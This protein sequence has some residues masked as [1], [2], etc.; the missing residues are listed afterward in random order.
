MGIM[1]EDPAF[2][3]KQQS[4]HTRGSSRFRFCFHRGRYLRK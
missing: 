1:R 2:P 3:S 4:T